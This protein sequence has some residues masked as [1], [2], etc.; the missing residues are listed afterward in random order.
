M[1]SG[2]PT[3]SI[4]LQVRVLGRAVEA[5]GSKGIC[6]SYRRHIPK[7]RGADGG[8]DAKGSTGLE[9]CYKAEFFFI[10]GAE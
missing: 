9:K 2:I 4:I 1:R 6:E 7:K 5:G 3:R 8:G 10:E